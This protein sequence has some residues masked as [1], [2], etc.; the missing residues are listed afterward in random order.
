MF[1]K[2]VTCVLLCNPADHELA[3]RPIF[4]VALLESAGVVRKL[5]V[6]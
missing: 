2:P 6:Y 4:Q 3:A 5:H 1:E